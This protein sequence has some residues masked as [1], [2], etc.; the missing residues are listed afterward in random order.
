MEIENVARIGFTAWRTTQK[1]RHLAIGNSLLRQIVI[2]DD[3]VH[4]VVAEK[5]THRNAGVRREIL[6]R[7]RL[8][9][10]C[11]NNDGI[12]HRALFFQCTNDLRNGRTLLTDGNVDAVK[13]LRFVRALVHF[14]LV[15]ESV[16]GD[17]G[18]TSLTVTND[19]FALAAANRNEGVE[20]LKA[21]LNRFRNR[22]ARD[23]ARRFDFNAAALCGLERALAINWVAKAVNNAAKQFL[24][25]RNVNDRAGTLYNVTFANFTV[26][27][28]NNDTDIV[29]FK[30]QGHALNA[31]GEFDHFTSLNIVEA[32][33]TG[34]TVTN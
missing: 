29:R 13:L 11:S 16:D 22:L 6:K 34:D 14:F 19:Q 18:F 5:F 28:E 1:K 32:V 21:S 4:A 23:D 7:C 20:R 8:R 10:G 15:D 31:V 3:G 26:G 12:F 27:S 24:A 30:V 17:S 33:N 9:S 2:Y 25:D